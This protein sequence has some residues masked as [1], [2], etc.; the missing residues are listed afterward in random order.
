MQLAEIKSI[1]QH[2]DLVQELE[3]Q[4][5]QEHENKLLEERCERTLGLSES[6]RT[7]IGL[8]RK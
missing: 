5:Y 3:D 2:L 4:A 6:I 8:R 1:N 7:F